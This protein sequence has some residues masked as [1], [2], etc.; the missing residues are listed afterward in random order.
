MGLVLMYKQQPCSSKLNTRSSG[1]LLCSRIIP[2][3]GS[4]RAVLRSTECCSHCCLEQDCKSKG[5]EQ[6]VFCN[7][8]HQLIVPVYLLKSCHLDTV[9]NID[10]KH[11]Y[12]TTNQLTSGLNKRKE[13]RELQ[14][15]D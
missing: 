3:A 6:L 12:N 4:V 15:S 8:V 11:K 10:T 5:K 1:K 14:D 9:Y 2:C 13:G 7:E